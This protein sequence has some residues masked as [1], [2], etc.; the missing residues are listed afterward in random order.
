MHILCGRNL[1]I[2]TRQQQQSRQAKQRELREAYIEALLLSR[3]MLFVETAVR[4]LFYTP[5]ASVSDQCA[6]LGCIEAGGTLTAEEQ[7]DSSS[8]MGSG[9]VSM[10][11]L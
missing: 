2:S 8:L 11:C 9:T 1:N 4:A 5:Q 7:M 6:C 10:T 3:S